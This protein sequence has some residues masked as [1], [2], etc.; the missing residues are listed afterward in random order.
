MVGFMLE[1]VK[2]R[3]REMYYQKKLNGEWSRI[4]K[5]ADSF[6]FIYTQQSFMFVTTKR[7]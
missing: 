2:A 5:N 4:L 6:G 1:V 3:V 7:N